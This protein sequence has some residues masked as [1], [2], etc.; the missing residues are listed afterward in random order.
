MET[1]VMVPIEVLKAEFIEKVSEPLSAKDWATVEIAKQFAAT[2]YVDGR[3]HLA[4]CGWGM[5]GVEPYFSLQMNAKRAR[6]ASVC[7]EAGILLQAS[8]NNDEIETIVTVHGHQKRGDKY[9][10]CV[11]P[12]C[13]LCLTRLQRFAPRCKVILEFKG[14]LIKVPQEALLL[15]PYPDTDKDISLP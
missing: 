1:V 2:H 8:L 11:V 14:S 5:D 3:H 13:A 9:E 6:E 10:Q 7:A 15:I 12:P 4:A